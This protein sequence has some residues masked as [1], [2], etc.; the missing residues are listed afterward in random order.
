MA[1]PADIE[2]IAQMFP[3]IPRRDIMWDLQ[4]NGGSVS[5]TTERVLGTGGL[6]RVSLLF[7]YRWVGARGRRE[8]RFVQLNVGVMRIFADASVTQQPPPTFQPLIPQAA[9]PSTASASPAQATAENIDLIK[10][11]NLSDKLSSPPAPPGEE[12]AGQPGWSNNKSERQVLLQ[13]RREEMVLT[14]RRKMEERER[15]KASS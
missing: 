8:R 14:A 13:R 5:A 6:E 1:N 12:A 3:Q 9:T 10:R 11:Y 2:Q 15:L 7:S 4:R